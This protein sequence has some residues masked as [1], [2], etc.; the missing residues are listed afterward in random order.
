VNGPC[1]TVRITEGALKADVAHALTGLPTLGLPGVGTWRPVLSI[2]REL[3]AQTARLALDT[4]AA[5]KAPVARALAAL[6]E[7]L[8]RA[9][10]TE[11]GTVHV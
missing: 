8:Q 10:N 6:T 9:G 2:L 1:Q 11:K 4:D 5:K 3:G 7:A